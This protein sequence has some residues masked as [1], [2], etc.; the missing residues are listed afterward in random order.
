MTHFSLN[1]GHVQCE[2]FKP[3]GGKWAYTVELDMTPTADLIPVQLYS[4]DGE[5]TE[6]RRDSYD[7]PFTG[8]RIIAALKR[9]TRY[10]PEQWIIVVLEPYCQNAV[11]TLIQPRSTR[12]ALGLMW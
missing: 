1:P 4:P 9:Q 11:P 2:L 12:A 5:R 3:E 10:D 7:S 6:M 8:D